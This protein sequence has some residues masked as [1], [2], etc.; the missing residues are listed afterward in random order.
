MIV[1]FGLQSFSQVIVG[2][3]ISTQFKSITERET[4]KKRETEESEKKRLEMI[5]WYLF[6]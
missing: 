2:Q 6:L 4:Q 5:N 1:Q 3:I